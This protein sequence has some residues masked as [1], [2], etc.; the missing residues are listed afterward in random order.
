M[1]EYRGLVWVHRTSRNYFCFVLFEYGVQSSLSAG[2]R[3]GRLVSSAG[4]TYHVLS[5]VGFFFFVF[6]HI[7]HSFS[8]LLFLLSSPQ[9]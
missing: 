9:H 4:I 8:C 2:I 1:L 5:G 7:F 6:L 3:G